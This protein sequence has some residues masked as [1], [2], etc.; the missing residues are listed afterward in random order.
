MIIKSNIM[1]LI[2]AALVV[3]ALCGRAQ[4]AEENKNPLFMWQ[5]EFD[6]PAGQLPDAARWDYDIGTD[7]GNAQLEYDTDRPTNVSLDGNGHLA[8]TAREEFYMGQPYT[9]A[10]IVTR[11]LYEFAYGRVE[12]RIKLPVGQGIW[13]AFWLL[14]ADFETIGWPQCGEID[15]MEYLGHQ[16]TTVYGSLHGPGYSG[17][18][19][20]TQSYVLETGGF[21]DDFHVFAVEW[22][23]DV[24]RWYVDD[25]L[26]STLTTQDI[27]PNEWVFDHPFYIILN[28]AVGGNWPGPPDAATEFPQTML[29]DY[30][31]I[32]AAG[33]STCCNLPGDANG[34]DG[35]N[36][37]DAV[38]LI[39]YVFNGGAA[40]VCPEEGDANC[41]GQVN[42]GDAVYVISYVFNGGPV[43]CCPMASDQDIVFI[44]DFADGT[45]YQA[46]DGSAGS[47]DIDATIMYSGAASVRITVPDFA[48][49]VGGAIIDP[50]ERNLTPFNAITFWARASEDIFLDVAGIGNNNTGTSLYTAEV[51]GLPLTTAWQK[52]TLPIPLPER[53]SQEAGLFHF[54]EGTADGTGH[55]IWIDEIVFDSQATIINPRPA[56]TTQTI[57]AE[58]GAVI[59]VGNGTVIFNVD[60]TDITVSAMPGYFNFTSSNPDAVSVDVDGIITAESE[61]SAVITAK[62][63][64]ISAAG[65]ITVIVNAAP[66]ISAPTPSHDAGSVI[67]I[68]SDTYVDQTVDTWSASW[69]QAD[70]EDFS[71]G[72]D[73]LKKYSNLIYAGIEFTS[74]PIDITAMTHFHIDVWTPDATAAPAVFRVKLV[75]FGADGLFGGGDDVEHELV[76]DEATMK[77]GTWVSIDVPLTTFA[78]LTTSEHLAQLIISGDPNTVYIDNIYF[79]DTDTPAAPAIPAPIPVHAAG[80]V[81]SLYSNVYSDHSVTTWS[82]PWDLADVEDFTVGSDSIKKYTNLVFAGI[83][84]TSP[85]IAATSMTHFHIDVWTPDVT[86]APSVFKIK[87]VDFG[88]DGGYGGGDDV[89]HELT[90]DET[91]MNTGSWVSI[92]VPLADFT[93]LI[94]KDHLAQLIISGDPDTVFVDNIYFHK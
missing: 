40:P 25:I 7:W 9:S 58:A 65:T 6:G 10:R 75:D 8:I 57:L 38:H 43:P 11:D 55:E 53:L 56:I 71:I 72:S 39:N 82:A 84:F 77:T 2:L 16:P 26:Y 86:S 37:G 63:G 52:Y 83:E 59:D 32:Q 41:D 3:C 70:V 30:V 92:D 51:Y 66:T 89:E 94:T 50:L 67:S 54:A 78:G 47:L 14:G 33:Y 62:I 93:A 5:D 20:Y 48:G 13:P 18:A 42:V 24:I 1:T 23:A 36:V 87:L 34:D 35:V 68:F 76:F 46:F 28:V 74:S 69:D 15:I 88:S 91:T 81:I 45:V 19:S 64:T 27:S 17:G 4:A 49:Y 73:Y 29:V 85:T 90:F 60:G 44:D 80:D 61:G 31:R 22:E 79:Y 12:A 21:N